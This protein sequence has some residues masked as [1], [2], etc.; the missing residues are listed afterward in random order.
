MAG[1]WIYRKIYQEEIYPKLLQVE[2]LLLP[3][4]SP[5]LP[6]AGKLTNSLSLWGEKNP[7]AYLPAC[8]RIYWNKQK[9]AVYGKQ[10]HTATRS[11]R[12][13]KY[14]ERERCHKEKR[15]QY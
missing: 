11:L 3:R 1:W 9:T 14:Q 13:K 8:E 6:V 12:E 7:R 4:L 10:Q 15:N 2:P 5:S